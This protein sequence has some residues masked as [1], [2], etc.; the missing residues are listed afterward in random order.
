[1]LVDV[2]QSRAWCGAYLLGGWE[3]C[4]VVADLGVLLAAI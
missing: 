1:L 2:L 4:G 3:A